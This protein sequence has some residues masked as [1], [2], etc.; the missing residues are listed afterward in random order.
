MRK[1]LTIDIYANYTPFRIVGI[2]DAYVN[3][4]IRENKSFRQV[5]LNLI[6]DY[7]SWEERNG[8]FTFPGNTK[9]TLCQPGPNRSITKGVI[10]I[11]PY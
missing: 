11:I 9:E 1:T 4:R 8:Y 3:S 5:R 6:D 2:L 10:C 7:G